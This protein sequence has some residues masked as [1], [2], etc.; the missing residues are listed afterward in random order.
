MD[1]ADFFIQGQVLEAQIWNSVL[2]PS[3][4]ALLE[5]GLPRVQIIENWIVTL[6]PREFLSFVLFGFWE[7]L[8][9][10]HYC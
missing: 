4:F 2:G 5:F 3:L 7:K 1:R 10:A 8:V 6:F 9:F